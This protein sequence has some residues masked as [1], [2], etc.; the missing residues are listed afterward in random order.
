MYVWLYQINE[1]L[2]INSFVLRYGIKLHSITQI[3]FLESVLESGPQLVIQLTYLIQEEKYDVTDILFVVSILSSF[4]NLASAINNRDNAVRNLP[5]F[6]VSGVYH[7]L[8]RGFEL[9]HRV[10]GY[11]LLAVRYSTVGTF[12]YVVI[13]LFLLLK[14]T[15]VSF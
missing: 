3:K 1:S 9:T 13:Y 11:V 7:L 5:T 8:Y 14:L 12:I 6:S 4:Y 10:L 15:V 2:K